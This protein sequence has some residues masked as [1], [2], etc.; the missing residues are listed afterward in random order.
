MEFF[1]AFRRDSPFGEIFPAGF[2]LRRMQQA[3]VILFFGP[4]H[5]P[6]ER[7]LV[8]L[9]AEQ[10]PRERRNNRRATSPRSAVNRRRT[11]EAAFAAGWGRSSVMPARSASI[12]RASRNSTPSIFITKL[13][14]SPPISHTQ[15]LNDCRSGLTCS[16]GLESSCQGQRP[17]KLRPCRRN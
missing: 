4:V 8:E 1:D 16:E 15:H 10:A 17:T 13:K 7:V 9:S 14:T 11:A 5:R 2:G 6:I 3:L 12:F